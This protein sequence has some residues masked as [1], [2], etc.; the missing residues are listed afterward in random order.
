MSIAS[1]QPPD[2]LIIGHVS[3]DLGPQ[4]PSLGGTAAYSGLTAKALG[5][6]PAVVTSAGPDLDLGPL[7]PLARFVLPSLDSTCFENRHA[8]EG[9][10]QI[11]RSRAL[12]LGLAAIPLEWRASPFVH[13][14]PIAGEVDPSLAGAF[15][16]SQVG[17]TAQGW[18]RQ[19]NHEGKV[20]SRSWEEI[21]EWLLPATAVVVSLEDLDGDESAAAAMA[22]HCRLLAVTE[23]RSGAV[24]Y[25]N[26]DARRIHAPRV[27]EVDPTGCGDVFAAAF[28]VHLRRTRDPWEAARLANRL[29]ALS[30]TR[31]GL[32]AVPTSEEA[33]REQ[34][35]V[36]P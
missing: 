3:K 16:D 25:W 18:L 7:A 31:R 20:R 9:R 30:V 27:E 32:A 11:L 19:W 4:G 14:A 13:L 36:I 15:P 35:E 2:Y 23:G 6:S 21:R 1:A 28:F 24:I 26:G 5:M 33:R 22:A 17:V 34:W 12:D 8:P 10:R 29:A